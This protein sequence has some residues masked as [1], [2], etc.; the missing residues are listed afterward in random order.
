MVM[1]MTE[2]SEKL[3]E[4]Y[5]KI[6]IS[7]DSRNKILRFQDLLQEKPRISVEEIEGMDRLIRM[8]K[9]EKKSP[10]YTSK[11]DSE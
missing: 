5:P 6:E 11:D 3:T 8:L 4:S 9:N 1:Q 7:V 10:F 2:E